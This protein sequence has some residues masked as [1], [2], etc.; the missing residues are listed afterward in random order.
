MR[1]G[2]QAWEEGGTSRALSSIFSTDTVYRGSQVCTSK[3]TGAD[4]GSTIMWPWVFPWEKEK[5]GPSSKE[6]FSN[7]A[8]SLHTVVAILV[9]LYLVDHLE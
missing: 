4:L 8:V 9:L 6:T 7:L 2:G 3:I 5:K 1:S